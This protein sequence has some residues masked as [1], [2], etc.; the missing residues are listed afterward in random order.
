MESIS[1]YYINGNR[2]LSSYFIKGAILTLIYNKLAISNSDC[3]A[4]LFGKID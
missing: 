3:E 4:L 2:F 1:H